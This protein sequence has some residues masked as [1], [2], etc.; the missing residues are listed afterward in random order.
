MYYPY[1][2]QIKPEHEARWI[3]TIKILDKINEGVKFDEFDQFSLSQLG[4]HVTETGWRISGLLGLLPLVDKA[5]N[6]DESVNWDYGFQGRLMYRG[7][8]IKISDPHLT[9]LLDIASMY[10]GV[11]ITVMT[12]IAG[13]YRHDIGLIKGWRRLN[14]REQINEQKY[15]IP[16]HWNAH[17]PDILLNP[18]SAKTIAM[19]INALLNWDITGK[20]KI[21]ERN[22]IWSNS[23]LN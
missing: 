12:K 1:D 2:T 16:A 20:I 14:E 5:T 8:G 6:N 15:I 11:S 10:Y 13:Y 7:N 23:V 18:A 21:P 19:N 4:I 22:F 9:L 17:R 3:E